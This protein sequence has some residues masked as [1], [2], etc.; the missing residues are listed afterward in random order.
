MLFGK[1]DNGMRKIFAFM[2]LVL[3]LGTFAFVGGIEKGMIDFQQGICSAVLCL[4]GSGLCSR[5]SGLW[6]TV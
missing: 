2:A 1:G 3:L 6:Y 4:A 5:L